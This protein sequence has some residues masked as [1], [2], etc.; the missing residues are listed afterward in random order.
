M[1]FHR[2]MLLNLPLMANLLTLRDRR[3][4]VIDY[5][6]FRANAKRHNYRYQ[7]N[8]Y[9]AE[10]DIDPAKLDPRC[11]DNRYRIVEVRHNGT[12]VIERVPGVQETINIRRIRPAP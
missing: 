2:D 1:V 7:V 12:V 3:Q 8:D 5:N 6:L 4:Q 10:I 11:S 9:V